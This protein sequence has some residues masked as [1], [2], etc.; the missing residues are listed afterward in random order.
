MSSC[1]DLEE[2]LP[3]GLAHSMVAVICNIKLWLNYSSVVQLFIPL[4]SQVMKY[5]CRL[6]DKELRTP[7]VRTM[8]GL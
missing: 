8:A 2:T 3:V 1:F 4:R 7:T 5:M 6:S